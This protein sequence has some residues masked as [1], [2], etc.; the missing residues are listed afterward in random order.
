MNSLLVVQRRW[1]DEQCVTGEMFFQGAHECYTLEPQPP[2]PAGTYDL[3]IRWSAHFGRNMPHVE[4][5]PG[6]TEIEIHWGNYPKDTDGCTLVGD[7][8]GTNFVGHSVAEFDT[9]F[10]KIQDALA[11]GPQTISYLDPPARMYADV[12]G[13]ISGADG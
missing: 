10:L 9:L 12:D 6:H 13:Q 7:L 2:I 1:P 3:T 11:E 4:A 8:I 5:V